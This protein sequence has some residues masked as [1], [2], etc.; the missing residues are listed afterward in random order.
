MVASR[1]RLWESHEDVAFVFL[2][3]VLNNER[4][5]WKW[6]AESCEIK[7]QI[8]YRERGKALKK[9]DGCSFISASRSSTKASECT[10]SVCVCAEAYLYGCMCALR[11]TLRRSLFVFV[12]AFACNDVGFNGPVLSSFCVQV[13]VCVLFSLNYKHVTGL[14]VMHP[15]RNPSGRC[16]AEVLLQSCKERKRERESQ[17]EK[18]METRLEIIISSTCT[19]FGFNSCYAKWRTAQKGGKAKRHDCSRRFADIFICLLLHTPS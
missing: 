10:P 18:K 13:C 14:S 17:P 12:L 5:L 9:E 8:R 2:F 4:Y 11:R 19:C 3:R 6:A 15:A 16:A 7:D 1:I